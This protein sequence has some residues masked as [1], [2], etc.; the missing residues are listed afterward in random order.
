MIGDQIKFKI[1]EIK[2]LTDEIINIEG[3]SLTNLDFNNSN[4]HRIILENLDLSHST[5]INVNFRGA[6]LMHTNF[7]YCD[8]T[9]ANLIVTDLRDSIIINA[10]LSNVV[11]YSC[12]FRHAKLQHANLKGANVES[13]NFSFANLSGADMTCI[14]L[15][16][17]IFQDTF[18]NKSTIWPKDFNPE[19]NGCILSQ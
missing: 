19:K 11:A 16:K 8:L 15:D 2:F 12:D 13:A 9:N 4:F 3:D 17:A 10:N 1:M 7:S 14:N 6:L 5:F 18:Y